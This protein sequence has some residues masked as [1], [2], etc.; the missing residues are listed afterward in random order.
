[1]RIFRKRRIRRFWQWLE[2]RIGHYERTDIGASIWDSI[3]AYQDQLT[4][5]LWRQLQKVDKKLHI[6]YTAR[7]GENPLRTLIISAN[8]KRSKFS[9]VQQIVAMAPALKGWEILAFRPRMPESDF[10]LHFSPSHSMKVDEMY[11]DSEIRGNE[12]QINVYGRDLERYNQDS[13]YNA[14]MIFMQYVLGEYNAVMNV[15]RFA[16]YGFHSIRKY[17]EV[18]PLTDLYAFVESRPAKNH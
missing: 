2:T 6:A 1:M 17:A 4:D 7:L 13:V 9:L 15:Q 11:F 12:L 18:S 3:E 8:G 5:E 14:G 16:F 10:S